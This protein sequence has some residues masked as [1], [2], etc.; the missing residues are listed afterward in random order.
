MQFF[1]PPPGHPL[2]RP[3]MGTP[4]RPLPPGWS[5]PQQDPLVPPQMM[6]RPPPSHLGNSSQA[7]PSG[8]LPP[9]PSQA[10]SHHQGPLQMHHHQ[11]PQPSPSQQQQQ[12]QQQ[13]SQQHPPAVATHQLPGNAAIA[14]PHQ[15]AAS[16]L[17][18]QSRSGTTP[19]PSSSPSTAAPHM[20]SQTDQQPAMA[21][22]K[23]TTGGWM[24]H[25][26]DNG[27][28]YYHNPSTGES[29]WQKPERF[30]GNAGS[31]GAAPIPISS[32][33]I[34][35]TGWSEVT[36][37][38]GR[39]YF[40]H[41]GKQ[42][43]SWSKPSE[44]II[45]L[46]GAIKAGVG[47]KAGMTPDQVAI[48]A[49]LKANNA[50]LNLRPELREAEAEADGSR[51]ADDVTFTDLDIG[52]AA[53]P[54]PRQPP[55]L[56]A[57]LPP[58][59]APGP[60]PMPFPGAFFGR[61][62]MHM[63]SAPAAQ[64]HDH[65]VQA[66]K[67][68]LLEVKV[69]PF[70]R[71]E[72]ELPKL[73][74]DARYKAIDKP[75]ER[76]Q[77]FD[78]FCR[79]VAEEQRLSKQRKEQQA[80]AAEP[81]FLSLLDEAQ[82]LAHQPQ[83]PQSPAGM[84]QHAVYAAEEGNGEEDGE[85]EPYNKRDKDAVPDKALTGDSRPSDME[86][87]WGHDPRWQAIEGHVREK[88]LLERIEQLQAEHKR[89]EEANKAAKDQAF[90]QLLVDCGV[91]AT[92]RYSK[93]R[94]GLRSDA[95]YK[96][97]PRDAREAAFKHFTAE[98]Q[99]QEEAKKKE[100]VAS[101]EREAALLRAQDDAKRR[102]EDAA[103]HDAVSAFQTL[104]AELVKD[105]YAQWKD[106]KDKLGKDPQKRANPKVFQHSELRELFGAYV[107][108]LR[109]QIHQGYR[110]LMDQKLK[111]LLPPQPMAELTGALKQ[112]EEALPLLETD[113]RFERVADNDRQRFWWSYVDEIRK[114]RDN[115]SQQDPRTTAS[116]RAAERDRN[117]G[118]KDTGDVVD[119]AYVR[120]YLEPEQKRVR[121]D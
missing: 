61:P 88:L 120:E 106:W 1:P 82:A 59:P 36:C 72:R 20:A 100:E 67:D 9:P 25:R 5:Q 111:P 77:I 3:P 99:A 34:P 71:W 95:R 70:S 49:R 10:W 79:N 11:R 6:H 74:G 55:P 87:A 57:G 37:A 40:Y 76:R 45:A 80:A 83:Q 47:K 108:S 98:L 21:V 92:S 29:S 50:Q 13:Q 60:R 43:T 65:L 39:K 26:S 121:R 27:Q 14:S 32:E 102:Q 68:L 69:T 46:A 62:P 86:D 116:S 58:M 7:P 24:A 56:P 93:T 91:T 115:P 97:M 30:E 85:A 12:Q 33:Q 4:P 81:A 112:F 2:H 16:A 52:G 44:V 31:A 119:K 96:A 117:R 42:E 8:Q 104:L 75:K 114:Q 63:P 105:P 51:D 78:D 118:A 90:R 89:V 113:P 110:T 19:P 103:H 94:E 66:F 18:I 84:Q 109:G 48:V 38:D 35:N 28:V 15:P 23:P 22:D 54:L 17:E 64:N 107:H 73:V 41:A 101:K 53:P